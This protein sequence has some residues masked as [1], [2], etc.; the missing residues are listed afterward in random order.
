[1]RLSKGICLALALMCGV[2]QAQEK[3][4]FD[5]LTE[6][7]TKV[8]GL[9]NVYHKDQ[10]LLVEIKD[11]MLGREYIVLPS[12]AKGVSTGQVIGGMSWGF[13]DDII[14]T[15]RKSEDKLFLIR[16]NVRYKAKDKSPEATAVEMAY[17]DSVLY[18]L[19]ILTTAPGGVLVDMTRVFMNDD[20]KIGQSL[21]GFNLALD[22]TT[23]GKIK[24]FEQNMEVAIAAVYSGSRELDTVPDSRGVPVGVH[25]SISLLPTLGSNGYKS[26]EADDRV[27][28]FLTV[29]KDFSERL[30]DEHFIRYINRWDLRKEDSSVKF[31]PPK[32]PILFYIEKT[33]PVA[34]RPTV[35]AGILEWNKAFEKLGFAGAVEVRQQELSD[36]WDPEDVRYNTF[37]WITAD[38]GFA[39]GPSRVDPRTGQ[40]LDADII[41]D[42]GFLQSWKHQYETLIPQA[43]R[44]LADDWTPFESP[45][46]I[47]HSSSHAANC[48][49]CQGMQWQ[50]GFAAAAFAARPDIAADGKVPEEFIHQGLKEVVMHEVG[51]TLGLRHNFKASGWKTMEEIADLDKGNA[52][53]TVASVMDY[54]PPNIAKKGAKQGLYYTQ[55]LGPYDIWAIEY[56]YSL[57]TGDEK[58]ELAKISAKS[59]QPGLDYATDEDTSSDMSDPWTNRFDL[60]KDPL[61][62]VR[63]QMEHSMEL[64][65]EVVN[66]SVKDGEGYQKARQAFGILFG[67]YWRAAQFASRFPGGVTVTRDHK[68][69]PNARAPL[70]PIEAA[71][72]REAMKLVIDGAFASPKIDGPSL[73]YLAASRWSH[74]GITE[75]SRLDYPIHKTVEM[76]QSRILRQLLDPLVL[77]RISDSEFKAAEGADAYT[78]SEHV[79]TLVDGVFAEFRPEKLEGEFSARKPMISSF[80][81]NLQRVAVKDLTELLNEANGSPE[82][83][84]TLTRMHLQNLDGQ[85]KTLLEAQGLKLDDY[86]KAHLLDS[87]ARIKAALNATVSL[88][89]GGGG[90][91]GVFLRFGQEKK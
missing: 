74:W 82:D 77:T 55:T 70:A 15:F 38:A 60:G 73:N 52:E 1:M 89:G 65:P 64:L 23:V 9:W 57:I 81:R 16:R 44:G 32:K 2:A 13:G 20:L 56:G 29:V 58:A 49:L 5:Q 41:F 31:C 14:W 36:T 17:S 10:Q 12:I 18:A 48:S 84:R 53:G 45:L 4:K 21:G 35:R 24:G 7:K 69:T 25:Y 43:A 72:Q 37:R 78:L 86:T 85:I 40:I 19:P 83:A 27:G 6:G 11:G 42:A 90:G 3:S 26:R 62:F 28:Y 67:E 88:S 33:V 8:T 66:S 50:M 71:K 68:G 47:S 22:R 63:R 46:A 87:Q 75:M 76:M 39:M 91:G 80:R 79:K 51:H 30:E 54:A 34:L 59:G 61:E